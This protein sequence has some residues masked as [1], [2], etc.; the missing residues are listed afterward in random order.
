MGARIQTLKAWLVALAAVAA[1]CSSRAASVSWINTNG[2]NWSVGSNWNP[3]HAPAAGDTA[4]IT[5]AGNYTVTLDVSTKGPGL[6]WA[7][8]TSEA[9]KLFRSLDRPSR[10]MERRRST[11]AVNSTWISG[12]LKGDTNTSGTVFSGMFASLGGALAGKLTMASNSVL[13]LA[14]TSATNVLSG[15]TSLTNYGTVAWSN[16]DLYGASSLQIFN[17]GLWDAQTN[18]TFTA[19]ERS[20][21]NSG[22]FRK[23]SGGTSVL[24][25]NLTFRNTGTV[26][27]QG[28]TLEI[29]NVYGDINSVGTFNIATNAEI[30][31]SDGVYG[32]SSYGGTIFTGSG[33]ILGNLSGASGGSNVVTGSIT[34]LG[35]TLRGPLTVA[36][37]A[38]R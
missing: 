3:H 36:S 25:S 20:F 13:N 34:Y 8:P 32:F 35:G 9:L 5:N 12:T 29:Q 15:L 27:A 10:S 17:R 23:S 31:F 2:G 6:S 33:S 16:T 18:N 38:V 37:N 11:P 28:G 14:G 4:I 21:N 24:D 22:T 26:V 7:G 19:A 1:I 30:Y